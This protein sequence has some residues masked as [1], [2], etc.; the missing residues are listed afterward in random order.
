MCGHLKFAYEM[1][2]RVAL[3]QTEGSQ[4]EGCIAKLS[5]EITILLTYYSA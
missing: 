5:C 1:P 3:N 2:N 4:T